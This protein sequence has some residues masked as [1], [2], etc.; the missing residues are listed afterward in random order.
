MF[1]KTF[2][3][4]FAILLILFYFIFTFIVFIFLF[5]LP[6]PF[7]FVLHFISFFVCALFVAAGVLWAVTFEDNTCA[8][9]CVCAFC[10]VA[11]FLSVVLHTFRIGSA[12]YSKGMLN[13]LLCFIFQQFAFL[14]WAFLNSSKSSRWNGVVFPN[15]NPMRMVVLI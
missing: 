15:L 7:R 2:L 6:F 9:L 8:H 14:F 1:C 4:H 3:Y 5:F 10:R 11:Y 12:K 13:L